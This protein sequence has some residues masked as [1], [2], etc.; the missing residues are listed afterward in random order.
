MGPVG[1]RIIT[2]INSSATDVYR[3][4]LARVELDQPQAIV[5]PSINGWAPRVFSLSITENG[6]FNND[7][8]PLV[9]PSLG[10]SPLF[11]MTFFSGATA[12]QAAGRLT[13]LTTV[14]EPSSIVLMGL[15]LLGFIGLETMRRLMTQTNGSQENS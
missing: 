6:L 4:S 3:V 13:S 9:P 7:S 5:G 10:P 15:G 14:P 11:T 1:E 12:V 2:I 8:L